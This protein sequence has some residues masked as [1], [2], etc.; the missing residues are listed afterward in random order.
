MQQKQGLIHIYCGDG[1]GKTTAAMGLAL[2]ALG[3]GWRVLIAQFLK[4]GASS[5]LKALRQFPQAELLTCQIKGFVIGMTEAQKLAVKEQHTRQLREIIA[6]CQCG[7]YGLLVLDE[8]IATVN[9]GL[10]DRPLLLDFL[11]HKP[12]GLE[13]VLT[14]REPDSELM[15][16]ADYISEIKKRKHPYDQGMPARKGIEL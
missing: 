3:C 6:R 14:G 10:I 9:L 5:E 7:R 13:V 1:K 8:I 15:E 2:R 4:D 12:Q 16:L 11:L